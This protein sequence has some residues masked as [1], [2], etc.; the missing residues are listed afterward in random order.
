M[1]VHYSLLWIEQNES[2]DARVKVVFSGRNKSI[3]GN[4]LMSNNNINFMPF[5]LDANKDQG[6]L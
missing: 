1:Y 5:S 2:V 6:R 4:A 3:R